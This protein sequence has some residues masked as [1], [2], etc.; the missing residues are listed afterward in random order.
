MS[1]SRV[2]IRGEGF[3]VH[4]LRLGV[5]TQVQ[6]KH[7]YGNKTC[8]VPISLDPSHVTLTLRDVRCDVWWST[9]YASTQKILG[10]VWG[11]TLCANTQKILDVVWGGTLC[12]N[13]QK[14]L[15]VV[16]GGTL[17]AHPLTLNL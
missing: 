11:G 15:D 2:R 9:L 14:I 4:K 6:R 3:G 16:W 1:G 7:I 10:V 5:Q 12:A 13:I 17:Y 8:T